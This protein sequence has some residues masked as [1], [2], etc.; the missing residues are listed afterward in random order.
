MSLQDAGFN[1]A[2]HPRGNPK[3]SGQFAKTAG[4]SSG[5]GEAS[6]TLTTEIKRPVGKTET[7]K[8][9]SGAQVAP[10]IEQIKGTVALTGFLQKLGEMQEKGSRFGSPANFILKNG[11]PYTVNNK[12]YEGP[13]DPMHE[14]YRNA[15]LAALKNN[16]RTYVE[17]YIS[18]HGVP[19]E[20]AWTVDKTGQVYDSTITPAMGITG[21]YGVP[22][23]S[24]YVMAAGL[25]NK[26]YGLMG[27]DSRKTLEPL[28]KG[29]TEGFK[30]EVDPA[31]MSPQFVADQLAYADQVVRSMPPT[32]TINT[33]ERRELRTQVAD[34]LYGKDL[35]KRK[36]NREATIILGLPGSGKSTFANPLIDDGALEIDPDLAKR[37]LPEFQGGLGAFATHE[38]SSA[39][40]RNVLHKAITNGDNFVWPRIDSPDKVVADLK[41]LKDAGYKINVK[42]LDSSYQ[43]AVKGA[44]DRYL[45]E[46]RYVSLETIKSYG[47]SPRTAYEAVKKSGL[48]N[49][50]E[51]Y[52][53][54][55][56][57]FNYERVKE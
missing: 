22:F 11:H 14:C 28:L 6:K 30:Q 24:D 3:N 44:V 26:Q 33:P 41:S 50:T 2:D 54:P 19:I 18:V 9:E 56:G 47:D 25:M 53:D 27:Y 1:E 48:A 45:R 52:K 42:F 13:R 20:H 5:K 39:I 37:Q 46:G 4:G 31:A 21:Y 23:K 57:G 15:T 12:T 17:G 29:K 35:D 49:E 16:G 51:A 38:E 40:T 7:A 36:H 43:N 34:N 32:D 8:E 10:R 55:K